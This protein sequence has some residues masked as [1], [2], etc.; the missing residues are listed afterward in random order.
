MF[1][2][3]PTLD[4]QSKYFQLFVLIKP[5]LFVSLQFHSM[6]MSTFYHGDRMI[7]E[8]MTTFITNYVNTIKDSFNGEMKTI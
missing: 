4:N 6:Y 7:S 1:K 8:T 3:D 5:D 2:M